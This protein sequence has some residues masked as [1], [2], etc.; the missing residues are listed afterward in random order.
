MSIPTPCS[1]AGSWNCAGRSLSLFSTAEPP[2][3]S[4]HGHAEEVEVPLRPVSKCS[5]QKDAF[6]HSQLRS[7]GNGARQGDSCRHGKWLDGI[8]C[9]NKLNIRVLQERIKQRMVTHQNGAH[10]RCTAN[11][12]AAKSPAVLTNGQFCERCGFPEEECGVEALADSQGSKH[13]AQ[14]EAEGNLTAFVAKNLWRSCGALLT[15]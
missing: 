2:S 13:L 7:H 15:R 10:I 5:C 6:S 14:I 12:R 8:N 11:V 1:L 3:R 4:R 9:S